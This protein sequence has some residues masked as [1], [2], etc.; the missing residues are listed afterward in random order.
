MTKTERVLGAALALILIAGAG[1]GVTAFASNDSQPKAD[2]VVEPMVQSVA[3]TRTNLT[4]ARQLSGTLGFGSARPIR[5][6]GEGIVTW[7][8]KVG[9]TLRRGD[10]VFRVNDRPALLFYGSTPMYRSLGTRGLV[11]RDVRVVAD[12]LA[13]LGYDIGYQPGPG[14]SVLQATPPP[15][16]DVAGQAHEGAPGTSAAKDSAPDTREEQGKRPASHTVKVKTGDGVLTDSLIDA[17]RRWQPTVGLEPTGVLEAGDVVVSTRAVRIQQVSALLG[18][19][20]A[21]DL[22]AVT[23]TAQTVTVPVDVQ[24]LGSI[25]RGQKVDV[26]MPD[27]S[28]VAGQVRAIST[29]VHGA[30]EED[31]NPNVPQLNVT[32]G[33]QTK[34]LPG[35]ITAAKVDVKFTAVSRKKVLAVPVGALMALREGG[36]AVQVTGGELVGV[37]TGLFS[38]GLVE[39]S[40]DGVAEGMHVD[41]TS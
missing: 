41:T 6:V 14:A 8:P 34:K 35:N 22:L 5:G 36:Y 9:R 32:I 24:D 39:I 28:T 23:G 1:V 33:L 29:S 2:L 30:E 4:D 15:S 26:I 10:A 13:A 37:Q 20:S 25:K 31:G 18:D 17:V 19:P 38:K 21:A 3:I 40:G 7:L 11:G 12:N 27:Q 16:P